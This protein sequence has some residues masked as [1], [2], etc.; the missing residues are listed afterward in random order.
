MCKFDAADWKCTASSSHHLRWCRSAP[1]AH[2]TRRWAPSAPLTANP[3]HVCSYD[4]AVPVSRS[5]VCSHRILC[6]PPPTRPKR[7]EADRTSSRRHLPGTRLE[8]CASAQ[9]ACTCFK[10][11]L[12]D[13]QPRTNRS[14][15]LALAPDFCHRYPAAVFSPAPSRPRYLCRSIQTACAASE[16]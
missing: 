14:P 2:S 5:P 11:D 6:F 3:S 8:G 15:T 12:A 9:R 10:V 1:C 7:P 13:A 4:S 16:R